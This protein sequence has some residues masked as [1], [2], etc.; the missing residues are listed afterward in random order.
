MASAQDYL[1]NDKWVKRVEQIFDRYKK[2]GYITRVG[3]A[4]AHLQGLDK[5]APDRS[6]QIAKLRE[7]MNEQCDAIGLVE[8]MKANKEKFKEVGAVFAVAEAARFAKGE[9]TL[10]QKTFHALFDVLDKNSN[11]YLSFD[12]YKVLMEACDAGEDEAR[13]AFNLLD[14]D[15]NGRIDRKEY[16]ASALK[17]FTQL[18]NQDTDGLFGPKFELE[19]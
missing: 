16:A 11:G 19:D 3:Y 6:E 14:K 13:A 8:G 1:K 18:D 2:D 5:A 4:E 9:L 15:K 12:E 17:F 7:L 10:M